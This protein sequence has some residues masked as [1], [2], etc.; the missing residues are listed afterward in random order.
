MAI[1]H[2]SGEPNI[3]I[4][5]RRNSRARRLSLRVSQLDGRV[6]LT[7]PLSASRL[8]ATGFAREKESWIRGQLNRRPN[9]SIPGIGGTVLFQGREV[10]IIAGA[11]R[12]VQLQDG[13][14]LVPGDTNKAP[15]RIAA[16]LKVAARDQLGSACDT[17]AAKVGRR[18]N[19]LSLRDTR[20]R[21]GSCTVDGNLMFSWR[22]IMAPAE[23]LNYVA[24]H[25]VAHLIQMNHSPAYWAVVAEIFPNYKAPRQ[26]LRQNGAQLHSYRFSQLTP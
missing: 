17:Y 14:L 20:S 24:A 13:Q 23:V 1:L 6:T 9:G 2:L 26:W 21:W 3:E 15:A 22:L 7:L 18:V 11:K 25:E 10:P 16:Y 8:E 4:N 19:R 5:L 12:S